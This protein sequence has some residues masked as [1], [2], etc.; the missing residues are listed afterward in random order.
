MWFIF[1][2]LKGL[3]KTSTSS[4]Y[5]IIDIEEAS[6]FLNHPVFGA[7]LREIT[8]AVLQMQYYK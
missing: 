2:Q 5:R 8:N 3:G 6:A 4:L 7:R 1:P